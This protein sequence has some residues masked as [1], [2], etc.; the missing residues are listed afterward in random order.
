MIGAGACSLILLLSAVTRAGA[1][2]T[3]GPYPTP[4]SFEQFRFTSPSEEIAMARSA[5]PTS[6]SNDAE[7]LTLGSQGYETAVKGKNGFVCLVQRSWGD[8]FDDPEFWNPKVRTSL[9]LNP[10][11]VRSVLP[12][13]LEI[14][15]WVL[16]GV[17]KAKMI[18]RT[19]AAMAA[20]TI[21]DPLPGSM[22]YMMSKQGYINDGSGHWHPHLMFFM[23]HTDGAT[24]GANSPGA[25]VF[26]QDISPQMT[27]FF[28]V[29][30]KWSDGSPASPEKH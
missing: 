4:A 29:V 28:V 15:R 13:Y 12:S 6:I 5:A 1:E 2:K 19:N 16:S 11:A 25:P 20:H 7:I 14:T 23:P 3:K 22:S 24:W 18:E 26:S 27:I 30:S 9:C 21:P 10:A 8:P 17:P